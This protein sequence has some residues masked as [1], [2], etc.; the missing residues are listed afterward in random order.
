MK[1]FLWVFFKFYRSR[2][3]SEDANNLIKK[4]IHLLDNCQNVI[5]EIDYYDITIKTSSSV[6]KLWNANKWYAWLSR[7][8]VNYRVFTDSMPSY[9]IMYDFK[10]SL[11]RHG[12]NPH[13]KQPKEIILIND[14]KC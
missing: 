9:S 6:I 10:E 2:P 13:V 8:S 14:V 7:G 12:H 4:C 11:K 5:V 3:I 1:K